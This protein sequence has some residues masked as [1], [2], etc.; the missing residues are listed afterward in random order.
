MSLY[1]TLLSVILLIVVALDRY[2]SI[3]HPIQYQTVMRFK[4]AK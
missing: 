1:V 2:F 4:I 3:V